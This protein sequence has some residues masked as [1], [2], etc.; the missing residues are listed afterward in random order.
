[1]FEIWGREKFLLG[2]KDGEISAGEI[3]KH[4]GISSEMLNYYLTA[5]PLAYYTITKEVPQ[6]ILILENLDPFYGM[7]KY[8]IETGAER[9]FGLRIGTLIYGGGKRVS[10][11]FS[12]F[13][14]LAEPYMSAEGN[15]FYYAGDIDY[16]GIGIYES[17]SERVKDH[18]K[19]APFVPYYKEMLNKTKAGDEIDKLP[20]MKAGQVKC[21]GE[22]FFEYF[23]EDDIK[24]ME[25]ILEA[26]KYVPQEIL[27][28]RD[29]KDYEI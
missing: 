26:G 15:H 29:Y 19:I 5:E 23:E 20:Q 17:F 18:V 7:R 14:L 24:K 27:S 13:E 4:C 28:V 10:R 16:E 2:K 22:F 12:D 3:L 6:N 11:A 9:I 25:T 21:K 8:S 1:S